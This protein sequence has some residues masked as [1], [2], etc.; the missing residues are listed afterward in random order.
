MRY[1][2]Q[3]PFNRRRRKLSRTI[4]RVYKASFL[5]TKIGG[6]KIFVRSKRG[7]QK[8]ENLDNRVDKMFSERINL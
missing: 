7:F 4:C 6:A 8:K 2:M 1:K 3:I 5:F